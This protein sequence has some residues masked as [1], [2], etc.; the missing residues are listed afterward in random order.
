MHPKMILHADG[1]SFYAS[2]EQIYRPDLRGKP[3]IVLSNNDGIIIALNKE[4]KALDLHRGDVFFKVRKF[5][6]QNKVEIFSSNYT[7]YADISRRITSIYLEYAPEVEEYSIDECFLFF[8]QCNWSADDYETIGFELKRRIAKEIGI[9][10]CVGAAPTKTLAKLYNKR[11]KEHNGVYVYRPQEVDALLQSTDCGTIWGI[12]PA[13]AEALERIGIVNALQLKNMP[14]NQAKS[15]MTI[16]GFAT[17]QELR[18]IPTIDK[19]T[20]A[21][22]DVIT[23]S[24]QFSRKVTDLPTLEAAATQYTQYAVEKLRRQQCEA[25]T[26]C[27]FISTC[28]YYKA[29][30]GDHYSNGAYIRLPRR[31]SYSADIVKSAIMGLH[32]IFR[33]GFGYK[34]VMITLSDLFPACLQGELWIDPTEDIKKRNFMDCIDKMSTR[35]GRLTVELAKG[36]TD[37][38]WQMKRERLSPCWTTR[39]SDLPRIK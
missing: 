30:E 22:H 24:R 20:R 16:Q 33:P 9:P 29:D 3:V 10:I 19:V 28:N 13:K 17:V 4:A 5:C 6:E 35:Y 18:G 8:P 37:D 2:C 15:L 32:H 12:G 31:T 39:L 1:N 21:K 7:L 38:S 25:E 23:Y 14:L 11:A 36:I 27:V 34:T 26:L